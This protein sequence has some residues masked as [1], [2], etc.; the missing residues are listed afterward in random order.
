M[1]M[2]TREKARHKNYINAAP[3]TQTAQHS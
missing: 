3:N 2:E 1:E